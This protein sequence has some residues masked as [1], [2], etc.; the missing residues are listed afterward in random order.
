MV[1]FFSK[2]GIE[3]NLFNLIIGIYI[4]IKGA[5]IIFSDERYNVFYISNKVTLF[6]III[7]S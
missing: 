4:Y 5:I 1:K 3:E 2:L 7:F 6:V